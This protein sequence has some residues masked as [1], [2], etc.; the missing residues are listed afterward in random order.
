MNHPK[1]QEPINTDVKSAIVQLMQ[2]FTAE[3]TPKSAAKVHD[4]NEYLRPGT[5]V[6]VTAL[7]GTHF[8]E[9][10]DACKKLQREGMVPVPHF[11]AR[12]LRDRNELQERIAQVT[13][14]AGVTRVLAIAGADGKP[15][16]EFQDSS[17]MIETGLF[18]Q[19]GIKS[20][21][22]AGHPEGSPDIDQ[23]L[24]KE[25]GFRKINYAELTDVSMYLVTQF[26]FEALPVIRWAERIREEGNH[27]PI[28]VGVPGIASL[29]TLIGHAKA[30]GIGPSM[31]VLTQQAKNIH[32]LMLPQKPDQLVRDL[33]TYASQNPSSRIAGLH[34][35]P[36]GGLARTA[37][38]SYDV[39]DGRFE[40][41]A[42]GFDT[43]SNNK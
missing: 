11:T 30:C 23:P 25:H 43:Q 39:L 15:A 9:T 29:K 27:L 34:M 4:F 35:F 36:L 5:W 10:V 1:P 18:D 28:I 7:P 6:Y 24:L 19:Y 3:T 42:K 41:N 40:L 32:K 8:S 13:G 37:S 16:G 21:G 31:K 17:A 22:I 26:V 38:W 20:I 14:E 2:G 12:S 33:A